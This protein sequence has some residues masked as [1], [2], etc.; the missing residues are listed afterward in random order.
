MTQANTSTLVEPHTITTDNG[1][2]TETYEDDTLEYD[3]PYFYGWRYATVTQPDG[4]ETTEKVSLTAY[5]V[6]FPKEGD[7]VPVRSD[8]EAAGV[9]GYEALHV[10]S[11]NDPTALVLKEVLIDFGYIAPMTPDLAFVTGAS[12][13]GPWSIF[14]VLE[15]GA[16]VHLVV[17][18]TS[19]STRH[20]DVEEGM[21]NRAERRRLERDRKRKPNLQS[22]FYLYA[23]VGVPLLIIIDNVR[24]KPGSPPPVL[25]YT[26]TP[27]GYEL[28]Q[29]D[30]Q[31][32]VWLAA[33]GLAIGTSGTEVAWFDAEGEKMGDYHELT[34][35]IKMANQRIAEAEAKMYLMSQE[36]DLAR[37]QTTKAEDRATK[38]EDRATKAEQKLLQSKVETAKRLIGI[39]DEA[40]ISAATGLSVEDV[41]TLSLDSKS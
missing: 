16:T 38:A 4:T 5:D 27:D 35:A 36:L 13:T 10:P 17:E 25:V 2:Y 9:R 1:Y 29:P 37:E 8:H 18:I 11:T 3:H 14:H 23:K 28:V 33:L 31:G 39:L 15:E 24:R 26:L 19:P 34:S 20:L 21:L 12:S 7:V 40:A 22:K 41:R 30:E 6:I 32:R